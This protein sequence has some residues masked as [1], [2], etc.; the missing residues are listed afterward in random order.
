MVVVVVREGGRKEK[1]ERRISRKEGR[2]E[3]KKGREHVV[4]LCTIEVHF[5]TDTT[6]FIR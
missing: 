4:L 3:D 6:C 5:E 2:R 1:L